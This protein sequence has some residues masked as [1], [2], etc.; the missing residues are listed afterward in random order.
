MSA[1]EYIFVHGVVTLFEWVKMFQ[2]LWKDSNNKTWLKW[3]V[4]DFFYIF[5]DVVVQL[6]DVDL[7]IRLGLLHVGVNRLSDFA[8]K[9]FFSK[10]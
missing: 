9:T 1:F 5:V 7:G 10:L 3:N 4:F 6:L 2:L 8:L